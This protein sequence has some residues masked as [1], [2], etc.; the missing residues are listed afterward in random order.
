VLALIESFRN[1]KSVETYLICQK[2]S[3]LST[4]AA[5]MGTVVHEVDFFRGRL[6]PAVPYRL[7]QVLKS[8]DP[9]VV[10]A[11]GGRAGFFLSFVPRTSHNAAVLY[12]VHGYHFVHK[13]PVARLLG[14]LAE[15]WV[16]RR[17]DCTV[18][19]SEYDRKTAVR[20]RILSTESA[21][22]V[23]R[24][25]IDVDIIPLA[26]ETDPR[27]LAF[28][29][30]LSYP[31]DPLL[32]VEV[33]RVLARDGYR[34]LILG[35]GELESTV[36]E[37]IT[38]YG[39]ESVVTIKTGLGRAEALEDMRRASAVVMTSRWEGL[40]LTLLEAMTMGVPVVAAEV[41]G[42]AEVIESDKTGVLIR[43]REP[44]DFADGIRRLCE[45]GTQRERIL[46]AAREH[47]LVNF[48]HK[49]FIENYRDL[50]GLP[51]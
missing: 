22:R 43:G 7:R 25:A 21:G 11:H 47:I 29:G 13:R 45:D 8:L 6:D 37:R 4:R 49:K 10:H 30:R 18:F 39:L 17:S 9:D 35:S 51:P 33:A 20:S 31:K 38:L 1:D 36:R 34:F 48:S 15:I 50:Y 16:S 23:I 12:T 5:E 28:V 41:A 44:R 42:L 24:N 46:L 26:A 40:P 14:A 32:F 27:L 19:V 3:Y 2:E